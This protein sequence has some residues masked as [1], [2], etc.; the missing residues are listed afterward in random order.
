MWC[1]CFSFLFWFCLTTTHKRGQKHNHNNK[2]GILRGSM[3]PS[4]GCHCSPTRGSYRFIVT[5]WVPVYVNLQVFVPLCKQDAYVCVVVRSY[6]SVA[7]EIVWGHVR[8]ARAFYARRRSKTRETAGHNCFVLFLFC[9]LT[10]SKA[11]RQT[12]LDSWW[13]TCRFA[14]FSGGNQVDGLPPSRDS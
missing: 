10:Q 1:L 14:S 2:R 11:Y 5:S 13:Q 3:G 7:S 12:H 9:F 8:R 6:P 4:Q